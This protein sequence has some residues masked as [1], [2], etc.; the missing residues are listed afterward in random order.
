MVIE[1]ERLDQSIAIPVGFNFSEHYSEDNLVHYMNT[2]LGQ[3]HLLNKAKLD[4]SLL[5]E[6]SDDRELSYPLYDVIKIF[7]DIP[8]SDPDTTLFTDFRV[9]WPHV[10]MSHPTGDQ[11]TFSPEMI[12]AIDKRSPHHPKSHFVKKLALGDG[13]FSNYMKI[14]CEKLSRNEKGVPIPIFI[15]H[16][17]NTV[18][19]ADVA[20]KIQKTQSNGKLLFQHYVE[21]F[22]RYKDHLPASLVL[23]NIL[24]AITEFK[25][26]LQKHSDSAGKSGGLDAANVLSQIMLYHEFQHFMRAIRS[27]M[28]PILTKL[29]QERLAIVALQESLKSDMGIT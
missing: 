25:S 9:I 17:M 4:H 21:T 13:S 5:P 6:S 2:I 16:F 10:T 26:S 11:V 8:I 24:S 19:F 23:E 3:N 28:I 18:E 27:P 15:T 7:P 29:E 12:A 14:L 1:L 20:N 22:T